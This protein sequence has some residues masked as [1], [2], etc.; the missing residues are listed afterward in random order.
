MWFICSNRSRN[1][2]N[3]KWIPKLH[4]INEIIWFLFL[5][6][7]LSFFKLYSLKRSSTDEKGTINYEVIAMVPAPH[8]QGALR[9]TKDRKTEAERDCKSDPIQEDCSR[10]TNFQ[11]DR[12]SVSMWFTVR[13]NSFSSCSWGFQF[14]WFYSVI[15]CSFCQKCLTFEKPT[16]FQE[17]S[18]SCLKLG[19]ARIAQFGILRGEL[20]TRLT[21]TVNWGK[22]RNTL[23]A[24]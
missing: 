22:Q 24:K 16:G 21:A 7:V 3:K 1:G 12:F 20:S 5:P 11:K 23:A 4:Q 8:C 10:E 17:G 15:I 6:H 13:N 14:L 19:Q 18:L 9:V 2:N